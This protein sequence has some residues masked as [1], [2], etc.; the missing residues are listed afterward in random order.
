MLKDIFYICQFTKQQACEVNLLDDYEAHIDDL[1]ERIGELRLSR[2]KINPTTQK[3]KL[4]DQSKLRKYRKDAAKV[5]LWLTR[6]VDTFERDVLDEHP[7]MVEKWNAL[8][9]QSEQTLPSNVRKLER[10]LTHW[11]MDEEI[12]ID[13]NWIALKAIR[14]EL[15]DADPD[16]HISGRKIFLYLMDGLPDDFSITRDTLDAQ[17]NLPIAE[18]LRTLQEKDSETRLS[19][20]EEGSAF[21]AQSQRFRKGKSSMRIQTTSPRRSRKSSSLYDSDNPGECCVC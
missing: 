21:V 4:L 18:K 15:A 11:K 6:C 1:R 3:S 7:C 16:S 14:R 13:R 8:K 17:P 19:R 20:S 9:A 2:V 12:P 5:D 10:S